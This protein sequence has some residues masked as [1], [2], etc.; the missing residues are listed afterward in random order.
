M[1]PQ[2]VGY[3][4]LAWL[5]AKVLQYDLKALKV[6]VLRVKADFTSC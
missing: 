6:T 1:V 3:A 2:C 5:K 4:V